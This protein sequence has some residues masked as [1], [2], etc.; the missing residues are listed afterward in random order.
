MQETLLAPFTTG[1][2]QTSPVSYH[3][4]SRSNAILVFTWC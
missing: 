1:Q 2:L 3:H 4:Y